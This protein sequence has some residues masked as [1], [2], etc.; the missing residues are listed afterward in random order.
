MAQRWGAAAAL[1][2]AALQKQKQATEEKGFCSPQPISCGLAVCADGALAKEPP[3]SANDIKLI[4]GGKY[5]DG[6]KPLKGRALLLLAVLL[7]PK[8]VAPTCMST[9]TDNSPPLPAE[10]RKDMGEIKPDTVVTMHMVVRPSQAPAKVQGA[11]GG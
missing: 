8:H 6:M 9:T 10:L 4:L 1:S 11:G 2:R 7:P 3:N 5:V